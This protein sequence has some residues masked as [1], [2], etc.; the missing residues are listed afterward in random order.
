MCCLAGTGPPAACSQVGGSRAVRPAGS[1]GVQLRSRLCQAARPLNHTRLAGLC[2]G[3]YPPETDADQP[4]PTLLPAGGSSGGS[5]SWGASLS[6]TGSSLGR[7]QR[8]SSRR[9][10][11][12]Y[13]PVVHC[14]SIRQAAHVVSMR[15]L[16]R[17][18]SG[19]GPGAARTGGSRSTCGSS[20]AEEDE[21]SLCVLMAGGIDLLAEPS[22]GSSSLSCAGPEGGAEPQSPEPDRCKLAGA[23]AAAGVLLPQLSLA[24]LAASTTSG[25]SGSGSGCEGAAA[26]G[27]PGRL[28]AAL[29]RQRSLLA[30][31]DIG[32]VA[33]V[34]FVFMHQPGG[35]GGRGGG[36]SSAEVV[37]MRGSGQCAATLDR[38]GCRP[39]PRHAEWL[40][41]GAR[42][43]VRDRSTGRVA[44]AGYVS[45]VLPGAGHG[46]LH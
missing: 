27:S 8:S 14:G 44:G 7:L 24:A 2:P 31:E 9:R 35:R 34:T 42:L 36:G 22:S 28:A 21:D 23:A 11:A 39:R 41:A 19:A 20:D 4:D 32:C 13:S 25:G 38:A 5:G 12:G 46:S 16:P 6:A 33:A 43:L 18:C 26:G 3:C 29:E 10:A 17:E 15:E 37:C 1:C 45:A 40:V 30:C